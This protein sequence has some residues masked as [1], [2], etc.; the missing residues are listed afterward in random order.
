MAFNK[1]YFNWERFFSYVRDFLYLSSISSVKPQE[2]VSKVLKVEHN[3]YNAVSR[4]EK[5]SIGWIYLI[6]LLR[7][8]K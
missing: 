6:P 1:V 3:C 7:K 4:F 2:F 8:I 5:I